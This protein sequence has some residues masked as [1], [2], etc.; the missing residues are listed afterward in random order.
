MPITFNNENSQSKELI[1]FFVLL[2]SMFFVFIIKPAI[3]KQAQTQII[4]N[5]SIDI[6]EVT[7][8]DFYNFVSQSNYT[9]IAEKRGWGY[10]YEFGW[11]KKKGWNWKSPYGIKGEKNEVNNSSY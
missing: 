8:G 2:I 11:V 1:K 6:N 7:I 10:V 5:F 4:S 9:T 3:A